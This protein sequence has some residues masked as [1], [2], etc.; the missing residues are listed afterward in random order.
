VT[1]ALWDLVRQDRS[2]TGRRIGW[3]AVILLI[4]L[5]G[6]IA[7]YVAGRS[8]IPA[9][10]RAMLVGGALVAYLAIAAIGIAIGS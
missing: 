10:M 9:S 6:P 2:S 8:P 7:Y 1:I 5:A 4:P 3:M